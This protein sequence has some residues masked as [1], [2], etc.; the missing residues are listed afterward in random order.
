[1]PAG[2]FSE[3]YIG[4]NGTFNYLSCYGTQEHRWQF[5]KP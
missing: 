4:I 5:V 2:A 1:M 3:R